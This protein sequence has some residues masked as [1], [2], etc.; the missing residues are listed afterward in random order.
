[1]HRHS[2]VFLN[3]DSAW[4]VVPEIALTA[5]RPARTV[6]LAERCED[7]VLEVG[8]SGKGKPRAPGAGRVASLRNVKC[9]SLYFGP[10]W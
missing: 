10:P 7:C 3:R 6:K 9:Q 5:S 2:D 8:A 4:V 1:M